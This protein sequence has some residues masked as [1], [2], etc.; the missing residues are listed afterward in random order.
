MQDLILQVG[1]GESGINLVDLANP[2]VLRNNSVPF[3][4]GFPFLPSSETF[5]VW[6]GLSGIL[7]LLSE[8]F[9]AHIQ[10]LVLICLLVDQREADVVLKLGDGE[11]QLVAL[12]V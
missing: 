8:A 9:I 2:Y 1:L 11:V 12:G 6:A 10:V 4:H 7:I 5:A 3:K